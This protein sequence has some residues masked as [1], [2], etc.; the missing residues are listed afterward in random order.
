M[1]R[2]HGLL[3]ASRPDCRKMVLLCTWIAIDVVASLQDDRQQIPELW[4]VPAASWARCT[5]EHCDPGPETN[6]ISV[7]KRD[8]IQLNSFL[9]IPGFICSIAKHLQIPINWIWHELQIVAVFGAYLGYFEAFFSTFE[10]G[11]IPIDTFLVGWTSI[12]QLFW[13]SLGTR[14]LTHP[15]LGNNRRVF[16]VTILSQKSFQYGLTALHEDFT[17]RSWHQVMQK[18]IVQ[19]PY[20]RYMMNM[21]NMYEY[22]YTII[23]IYIIIIYNDT[24]IV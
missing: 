21:M 5:V 3:I 10:Y 11:S 6:K 20:N 18:Q 13:G 2:L 19:V 8:W 14:V 17:S 15:H 22:V 4:A 7:Q 1:Y 16:Y 9:R 23:I 12:Y 24:I